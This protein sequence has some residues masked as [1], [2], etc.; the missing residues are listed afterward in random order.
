MS[1]QSGLP[2]TAAAADLPLAGS[3]AAMGMQA[4]LG[5][6][7]GH[8]P[9][10]CRLCCAYSGSTQLLSKLLQGALLLCTPSAGPRS[11]PAAHC[12]PAPCDVGGRSASSAAAGLQG[13]CCCATELML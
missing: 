3:P 8:M 1:W 2:L 7:A 11:W 13:C 6:A 5:A 12:M 10:S 4:V 9:C